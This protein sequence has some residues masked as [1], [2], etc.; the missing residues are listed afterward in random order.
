MVRYSKHA[1]ERM[2]S[3][4]IDAAAVRLTVEDPHATW[5]DAQDPNHRIHMRTVN[6]RKIKVVLAETDDEGEP[7]VV[8]VVD[9]TDDQAAP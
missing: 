8:T 5:P 3:R 4:G 9:L 7:L 1:T 2:L 6:G